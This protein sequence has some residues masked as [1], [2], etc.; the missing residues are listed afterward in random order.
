MLIGIDPLLTPDLLHALASMGHGDEI[1][2]V[3][4]NFPAASTAKRLLALDGIDAPRALEAV[5]SVMPLDH[6]VAHPARVMQVIGKP[7]EVPAAVGDFARVLQRRLGHAHRPQGVERQ[8][9]YDEARACYA[10]LRTGERRFYGNIILT[11]G[12]VD[13]DG[14]V[15]PLPGAR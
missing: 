9:F 8:A 10:I 6:A 2:I 12:V 15:P 13:A 3:D 14:K 4:A 11:K 7:D 1:A 5:L